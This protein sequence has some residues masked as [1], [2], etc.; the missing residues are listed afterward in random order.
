MPTARTLRVKAMPPAIHPSP[1][2]KLGR[3]RSAS[4]VCATSSIPTKIGAPI[5]HRCHGNATTRSTCAVAMN[6]PPRSAP[7]TSH[8]TTRADTCTRRARG[9]RGRTPLRNAISTKWPP[10]DGQR[11]SDHSGQRDEGPAP[12]QRQHHTHDGR[13]GEVS[14]DGAPEG[15]LYAWRVLA[16]H[17]VRLPRPLVGSVACK[18]RRGFRK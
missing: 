15:L 18:D 3:P 8:Q 11:A 16:L 4:T 2:K 1:R 10:S 13:D 7:P 5:H 6:A 17:P 12:A 14:R 9:S